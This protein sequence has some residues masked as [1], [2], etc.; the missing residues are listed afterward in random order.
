VERDPKNKKI[1]V[2]TRK[3]DDTKVYRKNCLWRCFV[4]P[5]MEIDESGNRLEQ[6]ILRYSK[7][8][9][10]AL[11]I[12]AHSHKLAKNPLVYPEHTKT[13]PLFTQA[14]PQAAVMRKSFL[15]FR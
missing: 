1:I 15:P 13:L 11:P 10:S 5:F 7:N 6:W 3:Q 12:T 14:L 2:S 8:R 4:V 9:E